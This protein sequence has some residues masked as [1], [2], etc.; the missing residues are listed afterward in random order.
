MIVTCPRCRFSI[1]LAAASPTPPARS[2]VT[3]KTGYLA[4]RFLFASE[5]EH[6]PE[7]VR[8]LEAL[9]KLEEEFRFPGA[10]LREGAYRIATHPVLREHLAAS[11][12]LCDPGAIKGRVDLVRRRRLG[13]LRWLDGEDRGFPVNHPFPRHPR[14]AQS[15]LLVLRLYDELEHHPL[16]SFRPT[17]RLDFI[18]P[19]KERLNH[20]DVRALLDW[21]APHLDS[22]L[23]DKPHLLP[24]RIALSEARHVL[25]DTET[26]M[27]WLYE[28]TG[29]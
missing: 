1:D 20:R 24:G 25:F 3:T 27:R 26:F 2:S 19:I 10:D 11:D 16:R 15:G 23:A 4:S 28:R 21:K 6:D 7:F 14:P 12:R 18:R 22:W 17:P 29:S 5:R 8:Q 9:H 13:V